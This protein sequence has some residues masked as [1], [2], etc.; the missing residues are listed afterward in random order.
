MLF[1]HDM[2]FSYDMLYAINVLDQMYSLLPCIKPFKVQGLLLSDTGTVEQQYIQIA[3]LRNILRST[4][5]FYK[6][7]KANI[8]FFSI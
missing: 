5:M 6:F 7:N 3:I 8:I 2:L 4:C 1:S